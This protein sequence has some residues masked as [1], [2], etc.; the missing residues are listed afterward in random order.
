MT[1]TPLLFTYTADAADA[2]RVARA[3]FRELRLT[4]VVVTAAAL[5]VVAVAG[6][7][8]DPALAVLA[9]AL[10]L[11]AVAVEGVVFLAFL[12]MARRTTPVGHTL[13]IE[14][15]PSALHLVDPDGEIHYPYASIRDVRA[16]RDLIAL[17]GSAGNS[18][19]LPVSACPPEALALVLAGMREPV[20]PAI[21]EERFP[22]RAHADA[23]FARAA[24]RRTLAVLVTDATALG[25]AASI[26]A[27]GAVLAIVL[28]SP[29]PAVVAAALL[30]AWPFAAVLTT[31]SAMKRRYADEP[32]YAR[33]D[34]DTFTTAH[35]GEVTRLRYGFFDR[36]DDS[37]GAVELR[38]AVTRQWHL[39]PAALFPADARARFRAASVS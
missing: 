35:R 38:A 39:Y 16:H 6:L 3:R 8:L 26:P 7:V 31:R 25:F 18:I 21:D 11:L 34:D 33:F 23:A 12:S 24:A 27:V 5:A 1:A 4:P 30:V 17:L 9:L 22:H 36:I 2:G 10:G 28:A 14:Y 15:L 32:I 20:I 29:V 37:R 13:T 19:H